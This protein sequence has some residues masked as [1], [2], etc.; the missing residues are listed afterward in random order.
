MK[1]KQQLVALAIAAAV[2]A[3]AFADT[4]NV[5]IYGI[6]SASVDS[7]NNGEVRTNKVSSNATRIGFKGVEDLGNGLK[8]LW[9]VESQINIDDSTGNTFASRNSFVGLAS[10]DVGTIE[11]GRNDTPYK[12][13]TRRLDLFADTL[14]DNRSLLG[15]VAG[16]SALVA[17]DGRENNSVNYIS[18]TFSGITLSAAY[19][20]SAET[21]TTSAD[22]KGNLWSLAGQYEGKFD[23]N[24]LFFSASWERHKLGSAGTGTLASTTPDAS[25]SA[26]KLGL[27]YKLGSAFDLSAIYEKTSDNEGAGGADRYG[28]SAYYL[29]GKYTFGDGSDDIK[30]AYSR[31]GD[32]AGA[33]NSSARHVS[34]GYDHNLSKR[35]TL[36]ALYTKLYNSDGIAYALGAA[37]WTTGN[38]AAGANGDDP[39]AIS[40]GIKH[41]F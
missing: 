15:S 30:L 41:S 35:T 3:P 29:A 17:F 16:R 31:A 1:R 8:A 18:P 38:T 39:S 19:V 25:E 11:L 37:G 40:L 7:T 9:Q 5:T 28:H 2:S 23:T 22:K 21:A 4:A 32:L 12:T 34:L 6:A 14:G 13:A 20:A 36:Y 10:D 33:A 26:W 24:S 27:G